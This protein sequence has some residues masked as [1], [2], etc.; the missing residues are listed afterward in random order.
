LVYYKGVD[1]LLRALAAVHDVS[2]TIVGEGPDRDRL[3]ALARELR[4]GQRTN[5]VGSIPDGALVEAFASAHVF[6]LPSVSRAEAFGMAMTE[7]MANG[8]PA[9]S[10]SLG[11]GTDWANMD[12]TTGLVVPPG[13]AEALGQAIERL[14]EP[15]LRAR[16]GRQALERV[17]SD[18]SFDRHAEAIESMY[19][20]AVE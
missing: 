18:F 6:V 3:E 8:L 20:E 10:T 9:I 19:L 13:N 1:L 7:A 5:F 17:R 11:T 15:R 2:L 4:I 12:G 16:L 14:R